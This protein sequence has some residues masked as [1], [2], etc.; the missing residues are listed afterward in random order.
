MLISKHTVET[1]AFPAIIWS[2]WQDVV[3]WNTWDHGIEFSTLDGPFGTLK[4]KGEPLVHTE[5]TPVPPLQAFI[6][7]AK[8]PLARI[9]VS[10]FLK[11][12]NGKTLITHQT[13]MR[14]PLAFLFAYLIGR[15]MKKN[16]P[17]E[18]PSLVKKAEAS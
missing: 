9:I 7:E 10:H 14:G 8:L 4:P 6:A 2:I 12:Y 15:K 5:L 13:E 17:E 16:L 3:N 11:E 1:R 18:M